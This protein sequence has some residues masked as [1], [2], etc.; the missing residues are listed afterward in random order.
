MAYWMAYQGSKGKYRNYKCSECYKPA[1]QSSEK[2]S[3]VSD[4][5]P[6]CGSKMSYIG[7]LNEAPA[8]KV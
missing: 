1:P 2:I 7:L 6:C 5:C 8:I 4:T 3:L